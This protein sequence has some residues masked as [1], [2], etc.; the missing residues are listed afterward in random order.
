M[1]AWNIYGPGADEI[2]YRQTTMGTFRYHTDKEGNVTFLLD[3]NGNGL[4]RYTYD[5]FGYP[6]W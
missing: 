2:F 6:T 4:E 5:A 3:V 1:Q